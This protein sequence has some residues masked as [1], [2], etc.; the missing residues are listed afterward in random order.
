[1]MIISLIMMIISLYTLKSIFL[2]GNIL[3]I[4]F[5]I[6]LRKMDHYLTG[7]EDDELNHI[8]YHS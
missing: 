4:V 1:M 3:Y 8:R 6:T 2:R 7:G 5:N